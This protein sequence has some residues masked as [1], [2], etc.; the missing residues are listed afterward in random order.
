MTC[1]EA[2]PDHNEGMGKATIE[3]AQGNPIQHMK[4]TVTGP[5]MTHHTSLTADSP[6]TAAHQVTTFRTAVDHIHAH[7]TELQNIIHT[8]EDHA[9]PGHTPSKEPE[10]HTLVGTGRSIYKNLHWITTVQMII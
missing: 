6:H 5:A 3:V 7:P 1:I 10:N 2:T 8:I 4:A 9:V